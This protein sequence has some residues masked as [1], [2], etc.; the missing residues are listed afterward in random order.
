MLERMI[1]VIMNVVASGIM[2]NPYVALRVHVRR[3]RMPF[4]I[5]VRTRMLFRLARLLLW[6]R[7]T[8]A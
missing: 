7:R 2:P 8:L 6:G 5:A 3:V 1:D 4:H